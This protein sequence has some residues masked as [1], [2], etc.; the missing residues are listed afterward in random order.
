M[1]KIIL[2]IL[3]V[4]VGCGESIPIDQRQHKCK[5]MPT[6]WCKDK[7]I[8]RHQKSAKQSI[9]IKDIINH[10]AEFSQQHCYAYDWQYGDESYIGIW[11]WDSDFNCK[12]D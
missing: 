12:V 4:L 7:C 3:F 8:A 11:I 10:C 1:K 6:I 5:K 2:V 9:R